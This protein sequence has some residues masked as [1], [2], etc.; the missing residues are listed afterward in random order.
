M[1]HVSDVICLVAFSVFTYGAYLIAPAF[2]YM[3]GGCMLFLV[4][5]IVGEAAKRRLGQ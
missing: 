1:T 3:V 5:M 2:G 4:A